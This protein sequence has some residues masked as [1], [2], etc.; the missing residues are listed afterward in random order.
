MDLGRLVDLELPE[1]ADVPVRRH[2]QVAGRVR[3]LVQEYECAL[4]SVDHERVFVRVR[5]GETE[6]AA[7]LLVRLR[8]VFETPRRP[9][10]LRH[11]A[12]AYAALRKRLLV[13]GK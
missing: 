11:G 9:E 2:H 6:D 3:K 12:G 13:W 4:A 5:S 1:L 10:L 8:D 7:L